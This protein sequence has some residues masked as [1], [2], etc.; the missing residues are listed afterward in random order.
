M[1]VEAT[2][3]SRDLLRAGRLQALEVAYECNALFGLPAPAWGL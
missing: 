2:W 3:T 1:R